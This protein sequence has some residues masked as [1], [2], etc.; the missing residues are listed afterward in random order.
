MW[1]GGEVRVRMPG[2]PTPRLTHVCPC[3]CHVWC[4]RARRD[5]SQHIKSS[6]RAGRSG[7]ASNHALPRSQVHH[8]RPYESKKL[9]GLKPKPLQR[10]Q[11]EVQA[12][13]S[14]HGMRAV[15]SVKY[16]GAVYTHTGTQT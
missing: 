9:K 8:L 2:D 1:Y 16:L 5:A 6:A 15:T 13:A 3:Q 11:V 4:G 14:D 12:R 7:L 10:V